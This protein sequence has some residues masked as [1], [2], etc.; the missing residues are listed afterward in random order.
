[1]PNNPGEIE[2]QAWSECKIVADIQ[3]VAISIDKAPGEV[4]SEG[5]Y[6]KAGGIVSRYF[7]SLDGKGWKYYCERAGFRVDAR[8]Q[9]V[10][11]EEYHNRLRQAVG[12]LGRLPKTSERKKFGLNFPKRRWATLTVFLEDAI[13]KG[14]VPDLPSKPNPASD[15]AVTRSKA[16]DR[17]CGPPPI[18]VAPATNDKSRK[19]PIPPVPRG[20][21]R[22]S[23]ERTSVEGF[24][25]APHDE[26][27]TVALFAVLCAKGVIP[28]QILS[29]NGGK[30]GDGVCFDER[31]EK[32][33]RIELKFRLS[34]GSWNH[35]FDSFDYLVC[36]ENRWA[37]FPKPVFELRKVLSSGFRSAIQP[38]D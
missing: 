3:R 12:V 6:R 2:R 19:H 4:F 18:S 15:K 35:P 7:L 31:T 25:Y 28:W 14:I 30:G 22:K 9:S 37:D 32:E 36:W 21:R 13:A 38:R 23:W 34:R 33:L 1:M 5:D 17:S 10:P 29:L 26:S 24:P 11:A 16:T 20:T 8:N 27:G